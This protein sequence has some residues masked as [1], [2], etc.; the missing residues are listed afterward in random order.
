MADAALGSSVHQ[1]VQ[2]V[3]EDG[4]SWITIADGDSGNALGI[5]TVAALLGAVRRARSDQAKVIVIR[6]EGR[7]FCVGGDI[8]GFS[9][10]ADIEAF[11]DDSADAFH[12]VVSELV[13]S[14]AIVVTVVQGMAAGA[15]VPLAAAGDAVVAGASASFSLGYTNLGFSFDG[16]TSLMVHSLGLHRMLRLA[17][18]NDVLTAD[19]ACA[20]GLVA[21]VFA[22]ADLEVGVGELVRR[23]A[24]GPAEAQ[25][26]AK[27]LLRTVAEPA[28]EAALRH[29][30]LGI[31]ATA[32]SD[33]GRE[34]VAAFMEK[35][36]PTFRS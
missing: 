30:T 36:R 12:R 6:S 22:D 15:G 31:R 35:R 1:A 8:R 33:D 2:Y 21:K 25:A 34:G 26:T 17:L 3:L 11:V 28:P 13:E 14:T 10:A 5:D 9:A 7:F 32:A 4:A 23:L 18:L 27:R 16:G 19:E 20:G 24:N 29:E